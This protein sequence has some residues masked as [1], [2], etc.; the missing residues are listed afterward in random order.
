MVMEVEKLNAIQEKAQESEREAI[1]NI[2]E[3]IS[4][5]FRAMVEDTR[6]FLM[7]GE[8]VTRD[9]S[10]SITALR[11]LKVFGNQYGIEIPEIN[12]NEEAAIYILKFGSE[13]IKGK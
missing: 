11:K 7:T 6:I 3:T 12:T 9:F 5:D 2:K 10:N 1:E 4:T 8:K 13:I